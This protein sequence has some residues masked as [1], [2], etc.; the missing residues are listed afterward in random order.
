MQYILKKSGVLLLTVLALTLGIP[1]L[2]PTPPSFAESAPTD[3]PK[4][5]LSPE[6]EIK[7]DPNQGT[8]VKAASK[9]DIKEKPGWFSRNKWWVLLGGLAA[10][11]AA[12]LAAGGS[13]SGSDGVE[14][15]GSGTYDASW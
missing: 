15:G 8:T 11:A 3:K 2:W 4:I 12:A 10:G 9:E 1:G 7:P 5:W 14:D 6:I 13:S